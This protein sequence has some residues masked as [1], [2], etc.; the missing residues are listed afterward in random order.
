MLNAQL[1]PTV[2]V[3]TLCSW[4]LFEARKSLKDDITLVSFFSEMTRLD[5]KYSNYDFSKPHDLLLYLAEIG[6][7]LVYR[8]SFEPDPDSFLRTVRSAMNDV[9]D[10]CSLVREELESV[11]KHMLLVSTMHPEEAAK[12]LEEV[13]S[14]MLIR[15]KSGA[16]EALSRDDSKSNQGNDGMGG[17]PEAVEGD[18][19]QLESS[20]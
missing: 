7:C 13:L 10:F 16:E 6:K 18:S 20:Q 3:V 1:P 2:T 17:I 15:L 14:E 12:S 9:P 4:I 5:S 8:K 19:S 11:H